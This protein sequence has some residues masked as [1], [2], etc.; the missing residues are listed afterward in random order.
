MIRT[1]RQTQPVNQSAGAKAQ[2]RLQPD[3]DGY[4]SVGLPLNRRV[5]VGRSVAL[6]DVTIAH[7]NISSTHFSVTLESTSPLRIIV[8]DSSKNGIFVNGERVT[9]DGSGEGKRAAVWPG[10]CISC[11]NADKMGVDE[12]PIP[13]FSIVETAAVARVAKRPA[14]AASGA[15]ASGQRRSRVE[16][17]GEKQR[18]ESERM[19]RRS[20]ELSSA[21]SSSF[22]S[23]SSAGAAG[24]SNLPTGTACAVSSGAGPS[25]S[26]SANRPRTTPPSKATDRGTWHQPSSSQD[27]RLAYAPEPSARRPVPTGHTIGKTAEAA[28]A[29]TRLAPDTEVAEDVEGPGGCEEEPQSDGGFSDGSSASWDEAT[30]Q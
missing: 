11:L 7:G 5:T 15:G 23:V 14:A 20:T 16:S 3:R 29:L 21:A 24:H 30:G 25:S 19:L 1:S 17:Q 4:E 8:K 28:A 18:P 6:N 12:T 26:V 9:G 10:D 27:A 22:S 13:C 2:W